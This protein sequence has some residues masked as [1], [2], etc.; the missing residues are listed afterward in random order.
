MY[1]NRRLI[2]ITLIV[3]GFLFNTVSLSKSELFICEKVIDGDTIRLSNGEKVRLIGVDTPE[4]YHPLKPV[5]FYTKEAKMFTKK[6]VE[7]KRIRLEYDK[8]KRDKYERL[9]AY[10]YL[11]NGTFLNAEIIKQGYGFAYTKYPFKYLEQ[12]KKY[13]KEAREKELGLWKGK[14]EM[15]F[16]WLIKQ[17]RKHIQ[18]YE[19]AN[20][21]WGIRYKEF[22]KPRVKSGKL[23]KVL[24]NLR[25]WINEYSNKDLAS[26]LY[27]NGW[28]KLK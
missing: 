1:E 21:L 7:G 11:E 19:M 14:G 28:L 27:K 4:F 23:V 9:L 3:S 26:Q 17:K 16:R 22:I 13:E 5:E 15:E 24:E 12:F 2:I 8:E 25:Q 6:L 20:N 18:L 10:V